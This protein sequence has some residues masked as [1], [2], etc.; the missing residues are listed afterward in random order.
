MSIS[1]PPSNTCIMFLVRH[2][3]TAN[4]LARPPILQGG[5]VDLSLS[6]EGR[7]QA[8][9]AAALLR[10]W[11]LAAAYSSSMKRARETAEIIATPHGLK[12]TALDAIREVDVGS[13]E[14]RSWQEIAKTEPE[15]YARFMDDASQYGYVGGEN[16]T[17][18]H[19]RVTPVL[20]ELMQRHLGQRIVVVGHNVV[21]RSFL[22]PLMHAPMSQART[23]TQENCC[24]N[25]IRWREGALKLL[26]LNAAFHLEGVY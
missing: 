17:Q 25:V 4:N 8:Q 1:P 10:D 12:V 18:V 11:R 3:A 23:I 9:R 24:V 7:V 13:W 2:G 14:G 19:E 22:A 15:A 5:G 21:N 20:T 26:T 6:E 16:L